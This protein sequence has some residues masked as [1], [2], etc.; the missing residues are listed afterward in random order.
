MENNHDHGIDL[1]QIASQLTA[2]SKLLEKRIMII[3]E[4]VTA[5]LTKTI[6]ANLLMLEAADAGKPI[7]IYLNSPGGEINSGFAIYDTI[8]FL[9]SP[10]Q[11]V[12]TGL[13]ASMATI[14]FVAPKKEH[15]Y[16]MPNAKFLIHQPLIMGQI[17]GQASDLEISAREI[18]KTRQKTNEI[19]ARECGQPLEKVEADTSRDYWMSAVEA[20]EYGL[21]TKIIESISELK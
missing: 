16:S 20:K 21:V 3:S 12:V 11:I 17:Y 15:R 4:P 18:L 10:V 13:A 14:L 6:V 7:T 1:G 8:K 2:T 19:L 5:E 9:K